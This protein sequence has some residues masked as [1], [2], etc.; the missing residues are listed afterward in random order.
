MNKRIFIF[1]ILAL[2]FSFSLFGTEV[3]VGKQEI[4]E[5]KN[6]ETDYI[7]V[8]EGL[9][10]SGSADDIYFVG[11]NFIFNGKIRSGIVAVGQDLEINQN[12]PNDLV[13]IGKNIEIRGTVNGSIFIA[14][15]SVNID[16]ES[17]I[18]GDLFVASSNFRI[19]G[20][21]N[22]NIYCASENLTISNEVNGNLKLTVGKLYISDNGKINGDLDYRSRSKIS[23]LEQSKVNGKTQFT[24]HYRGPKPPPFKKVFF[25]IMLGFTFLWILSFLI[26]GALLLVF[27]S[28]N[29]LEEQKTRKEFWFTSLWGLIPFFIYPVVVIILL[30]AGITFPLGIILLL[31]GFPILFVTQ[32]I[33]VTLFG[34]FLF[35]VFKWNF[36]KRFLHFLFGFI[37]FAILTFIPFISSI[38]TIFFSSLGWGLIISKLFNKKF[39]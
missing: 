23:E 33:G 4:I 15:D 7:F 37:F 10:F 11:K 25:F 30:F 19:N 27:P 21:V 8:G 22:G 6:F 35:D 34:Q 17:V 2:I 1:T 5:D 26:G 20:K 38:S 36:S 9:K 32:V 29:I 31:S 16:K 12:I 24:E 28:L 3:K 13:A 39:V 14:G 18:D